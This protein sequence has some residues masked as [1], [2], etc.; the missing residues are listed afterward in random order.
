MSKKAT[1]T[2]TVQVEDTIVRFARISIQASSAAEAAMMARR[3]AYDRDLEMREQAADRDPWVYSI[4]GENSFG[5]MKNGGKGRC[6]CDR[7]EEIAAKE[8]LDPSVIDDLY[9]EYGDD[10]PKFFCN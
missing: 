3:L 4:E 5:V 7:L 6:L 2:Y 1:K 9:D 8:G 10:M